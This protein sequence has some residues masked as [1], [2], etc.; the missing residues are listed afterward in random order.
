[1]LALAILFR[2]FHIFFHLI[3][4]KLSKEILAILYWETLIQL[5]YSTQLDDTFFDNKIH[6][7]SAKSQII[8]YKMQMIT[9]QTDSVENLRRPDTDDGACDIFL[10]V[11]RLINRY[12]C[13]LPLRCRLGNH[14]DVHAGE[15]TMNLDRAEKIFPIIIRLNPLLQFLVIHLKTLTENDLGDEQGTIKIAQYNVRATGHVAKLRRD[16]GIDPK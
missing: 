9:C 1:M 2:L 12:F 6:N 15:I 11:L 7:M 3:H 4:V 5:V 14:P 16:M 10:T 13:K 8:R